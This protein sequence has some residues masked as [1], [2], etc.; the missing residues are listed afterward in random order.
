MSFSAEPAARRFSLSLFLALLL[1]PSLIKAE[2]QVQGR[3]GFHGVFQLGRPFP[4]EVEL[5]P[6]KWS[7]A[8]VS[9]QHY[10]MPDHDII[11][12]ACAYSFL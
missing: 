12:S 1:Y 10:R 5:A 8:H 3:I 7:A 4:I 11:V 9:S 2:I 6:Q